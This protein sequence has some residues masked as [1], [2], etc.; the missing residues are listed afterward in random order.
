M[1]I[2][3]QSLHKVQG[4]TEYQSTKSPSM[5][6]S[7][8]VFLRK[9]ATQLLCLMH[10]RIQLPNMGVC[11]MIVYILEKPKDWHLPPL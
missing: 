1:T 4:F 10:V 2:N 11:H 9:G 6:A 7:S 3:N 8:M 5:R